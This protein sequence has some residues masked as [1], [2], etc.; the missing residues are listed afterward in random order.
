MPS[1]EMAEP[2][3]AVVSR[4]STSPAV[5]GLSKRPEKIAQC[6][7]AEEVEAL[8]SDFKARFGLRAVRGADAGISRVGTR[9]AEGDEVLL[10]HALDE[11]VDEIVELA[12][13]HH[14]VELPAQILV[15]K[16]AILKSAAESL[17]QIVEIVVELAEVGVG[18][19]E[20]GVEK[21]I[22]KRL[23]KIFEVELGGEIAAIFGVVNAFHAGSP[24]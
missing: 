20:A 23:E 7:E 13:G 18:I 8:V 15:K 5:V 22:R 12:L 9:A 3:V 16:L 6:L 21:I 11:L 19:V 2:S 24:Q 1:R 10:V 4:L 17:T 14:L